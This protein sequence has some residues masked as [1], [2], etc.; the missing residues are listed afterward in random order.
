[1]AETLNV[2]EATNKLL[3]EADASEKKSAKKESKAP[4]KKP[5]SVKESVS[6]RVR[7]TKARKPFAIPAS[8]LKFESLTRF[9]EAEGDD[10]ADDDFDVTAD[11]TPE[12]DVVLVI[13]PEMEEVPEDAA[14]AQAA[15]EEMVGDHVCKCSICGANY[16]TD[17]EIDEEVEI[18]DAECPVCGETGDQIVVGVIT[19]VGE[20]SDED[21]ADLDDVD[22]ED[23]EGD[24]EV[25]VDVDF[26]D[27]DAE[28][29]GED[30]DYD[31][32]L[33]RRRLARKPMARRTESAKRMSKPMPRRPKTRTESARPARPV[34]NVASRKTATAMPEGY[35]F[36]E[37]TF[38][39]MLTQFAKENYENVRSVRISKGSVKRGTLTLEGIV[40]T[41]KGSK[42]TIKFVAE[43][44]KPTARM[45]I[46]FREIGPFTESIKS[47]K[48]SFILECRL[49][50]KAIRP[51]AL[52]Y[53]YV[54]KNAGMK[55]SRARYSVTGK[56]LSESV[57]RPARKPIARKRRT[58]K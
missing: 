32:S 37:V 27:I 21:Q 52:R 50:G 41:T 2:F 44:F 34:R 35:A 26:D 47:T 10:T 24:E 16:V 56:V 58:G 13:D 49:V 20:L 12:D 36:D 23:E 30:E 22:V 4:A 45:T 38:N 25:D 54:A 42:R 29:E 28:D 39:R 55:E 8:K 14:E 51:M 5:A 53:S 11:Y 17:T 15:A 3:R 33:N 43:D 1:M 46:K 48:P 6:K 7:S 57:R 40:T 31:E 19:P 18:E 9:H